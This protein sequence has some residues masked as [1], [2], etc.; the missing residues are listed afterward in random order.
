MA[1]DKSLAETIIEGTHQ[2]AEHSAA[3]VMIRV[4]HA[5]AERAERSPHRFITVHDILAVAADIAT[6]LDAKIS[7]R[8]AERERSDG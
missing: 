8:I 6:K 7:E 3:M 2:M 1:N 4:L 5:L